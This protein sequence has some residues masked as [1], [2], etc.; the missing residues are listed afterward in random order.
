VHAEQG[1]DCGTNPIAVH[2]LGK[3]L[4]HKGRKRRACALK[5]QRFQE[6]YRLPATKIT[7]PGLPI[8]TTVS[9]VQALCHRPLHDLM[10]DTIVKATQLRSLWLKEF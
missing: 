8:A 6:I 5:Q 10:V 2:E 9:I 1:K 7:S 4:R 3:N